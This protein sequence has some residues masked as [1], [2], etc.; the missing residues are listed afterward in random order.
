[1]FAVAHDITV[2]KEIERVKQEFVA[3]VSHDL[4]TPLT[5]IQGFLALL[6]TGMYGDLNEYG[7]E[8][9]TLADD[10][11]RRLIALINDLLDIE[12]LESGNLQMEIGQTS[13]AEVFTRS[14]NSVA[15]FASLHH[16]EI[17]VVPTT[18]SIMADPDRLVQVMVNLISNAVK[19][20]PENGHVAVAVEDMEDWTRI[21]VRDSGCGVPKQFH[22]AVFE[23]FQQVSIAD[24]KLKGG[25]GLGLAICKAIVEGHQGVIGVDSEEGEGSTFWFKI[26]KTRLPVALPEMA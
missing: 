13:L 3:M 17:E 8:S 19:F 15:G 11:V 18:V 20:S 25:S 4:R 5:S 16:V 21:T 12:K 9:R 26:P 24:A 14:V 6:D 2:R 1:M 22:N 23:R 7:R 10:N